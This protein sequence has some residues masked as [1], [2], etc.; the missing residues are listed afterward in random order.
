MCHKQKLQ[1]DREY[2]KQV[3][4]FAFCTRHVNKANRLEA[5]V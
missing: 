5:K 1:R 3:E 2:Y 4:T